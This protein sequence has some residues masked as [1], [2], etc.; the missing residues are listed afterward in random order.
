[1][2]IEIQIINAFIDGESGGNPAG[3]VL[4]ADKLSVSQKLKIATKVG[5]SETAFV[6]SSKSADFKLDFFTPKRQ[7][8]HCGHATIATFSYLQQLGRIGKAATSKETIDGDRNIFIDGDM[9]FMEQMAPSYEEIDRR[10]DNLISS[11]GITAHD[12][13]PNNKPFIVNTG[14]SFL[15]VPLKDETTVLSAQP[16]FEAIHM[17]SEEF[18]LIGYYIFS[19]YTKIPRRVAGTRMFAPRYGINEE[20]A[21]GMAAGPLAC[22]LYDKMGINTE[23]YLIE[24]GHLMKPPLPSVITVKLN[25]VNGKIAGLIA[26]GKAKVIKSL[27]I[28]I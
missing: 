2:E 25:F 20:S 4:D 13:I 10:M 7:I 21:T 27:T 1:M 9:A 11:L 24:Q 28:S 22:Y 12:L 16:D 19:Q 3:V 14:N 15:V 23:V 18:D 26:G 5:L 17:I 8:A 6:S